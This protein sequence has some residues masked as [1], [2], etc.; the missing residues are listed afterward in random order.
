[1]LVFLREK[2]QAPKLLFSLMKIS[3][4]INLHIPLQIKDL[5]INWK[6]D[7]LAIVYGNVL[8]KKTLQE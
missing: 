1:M 2:F 8:I 3:S 6:K 4:L 7:L 5:L